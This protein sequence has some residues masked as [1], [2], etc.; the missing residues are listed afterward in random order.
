[1]LVLG[2]GWYVAMSPL[3]EFLYNERS[4]DAEKDQQRHG[5]AESAFFYCFR[6]KM[7]ERVSEQSAHRETDQIQEYF[8]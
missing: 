8:F 7:D 6:D 1:M 3:N 5:N 2:G 4:E